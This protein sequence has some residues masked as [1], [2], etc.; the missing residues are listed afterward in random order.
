MSGKWAD[1]HT[2][3]RHS[4]GVE[5]PAEIV[6][7]AAEMGMSCLSLTDHDTCAGYPE[8]FEAGEKYG[9]E[10]IPGIEVS[11]H[12]GEKSVHVLGYFMDMESDDF[13]KLVS[14]NA[15]G[16]VSRMAR[17]V[18]KLVALG[19]KVT[20]D[21]ILGFTG[22]ATVGRAQ[23]ARYLVKL[24]YFKTVEEVFEKLLGDGGSVYEPVPKFTPEEAIAII[25]S[26]GGVSSL[27]HPGHTGMDDD[28][29][30]LAAEGLDG[31]EA[32]S[33]QHDNRTV[34]KYL[35][36]AEEFNLLVT[37]GSDSHGHGRHGRSMGSVRL[38]Y[39]RVEKLKER[40]AL[41]AT[42]ARHI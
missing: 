7:V 38:S 22:E 42:A 13:K 21:D 25:K 18:E 39:G 23:L 20:L 31:I 36:M 29:G 27:A 6:R 8:M 32:Y 14:L 26:A 12:S 30:H 35:A 11:A 19:Y 2:H 41:S 4:D 28:I 15:E 3:S 5:N 34:E 10:I 40:A 1:L 16:R 17:M 37:G 24:G 33:P 9:V